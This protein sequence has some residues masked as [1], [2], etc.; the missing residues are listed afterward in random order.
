MRDLA[1]TNQWPWQVDL[2]P[3]PDPLLIASPQTVCTA[4]SVILD[5]C[6]RWLD[7]VGAVLRHHLPN[8]WVIDLNV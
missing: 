2:V 6:P 5:A 3:N 8:A 1:E 7:L 4:D